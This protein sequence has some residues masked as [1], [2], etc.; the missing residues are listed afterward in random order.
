MDDNEISALSSP[1]NQSHPVKKNKPLTHFMRLLEQSWA[2]FVEQRALHI[3]PAPKSQPIT[4]STVM[5]ITL[6]FI[7]SSSKVL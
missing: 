4:E 3:V 2:R 1:L 7:L 6:S 5:I